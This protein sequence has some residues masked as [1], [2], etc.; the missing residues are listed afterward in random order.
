VK[1]VFKLIMEAFTEHPSS[2]GESYFEHM[3]QAIKMSILSIFVCFVF[4]IHS[5]FPFLFKTLGCDIVRYINGKCNRGR[6]GHDEDD[7]V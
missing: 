2:V 1:D 7:W 3:L 4:F 5:I 6:T